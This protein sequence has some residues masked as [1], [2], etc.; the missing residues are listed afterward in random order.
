MIQDH[1]PGEWSQC[2]LFLLLICDFKAAFPPCNLEWFSRPPHRCSK[3]CQLR[4]KPLA[5]PSQIFAACPCEEVS[6][7]WGQEK[8]C[9]TVGEACS[10]CHPVRNSSE[11]QGQAVVTCHG[12]G[13][14]QRQWGVCSG[15]RLCQWFPEGGPHTC[16]VSVSGFLELRILRPCGHPPK[17]EPLPLGPGVFFNQASS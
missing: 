14:G 15:R 16:S 17:S 1:N 6:K 3:C 9:V 11:G 5:L 8:H 4:V 10:L 12:T 13:M 2:K 7:S